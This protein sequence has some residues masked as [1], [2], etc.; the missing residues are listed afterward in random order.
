M[1]P[2][3]PRRVV[4]IDSGVDPMHPAIRGRCRVIAGPHFDALGV[5]D[6]VAGDKDA[7]GHGTAVAAT[8]VQF[9]TADDDIELTSL[10]VFAE[11]P[12]C[13][14]AAVLHAL[15][16]ALQLAPAL[17]NL[18]LGTTSLRHRQALLGW[19]ALAKEHGTRLVAPAS[20]GGLACDPGNLAGVEAVVAD[21]NVLPMLPELRPHGGRLLWFASPLGPRDAG[22]LRRLTA[23]GDSLATAA[24]TGWL[25]RR[26]R[27]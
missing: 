11:A 1:N 18:S 9:A 16:H 5:G 6:P 14:F 22:G 21:G 24:V 19:L 12:T 2:P 13:E 26:P 23:R 8:I 27:A 10:R 4:I 3:G 25:L 7:L 15:H 20:Y 17:I